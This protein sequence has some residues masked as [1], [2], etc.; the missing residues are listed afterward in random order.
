[1]CEQLAQSHCVKWNR[2]SDMLVDVLT[3]LRYAESEIVLPAR[4]V[5]FSKVTY[6]YRLTQAM[7]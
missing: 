4:E 6:M 1:V 2:T 5:F 7:C 3:P